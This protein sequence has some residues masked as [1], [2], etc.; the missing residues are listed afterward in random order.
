VDCAVAP[1]RAASAKRQSNERQLSKRTEGS[2]APSA[3]LDFG[4]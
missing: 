2:H 4:A 3:P 1:R